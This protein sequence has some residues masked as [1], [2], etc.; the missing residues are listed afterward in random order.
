M[1]AP[2]VETLAPPY[3]VGVLIERYAHAG[4]LLRAGLV[5]SVDGAVAADGRSAGLSGSADRAAFRALRACADAVV[6][7]AGTARTEGYG[8]VRLTPE[9]AAHRAALGLPDPRLVL[10]SRAGRF[11]PTARCF[12]EQVAT[13]TVVVTGERGRAAAASVA[14]V[15]E[16]VVVDGPDGNPDPAEVAAALRA[17]GLAHLLC[18]GGPAL[19]TDLLRAGLVDELCLTH[20]PL[21][22]GGGPPLVGLLESPLRLE[23][24]HLLDT[25]EALLGRYAVRRDDGA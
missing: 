14:G 4:V 21:L 24:R 12:T 9:G 20:A 3:D 23:R 25:G 6:V 1:T 7:G 10:V 5:V 18:E 13:P 19:L 2:A 17:R 8:P 16:V 15:A 22:V 11:D